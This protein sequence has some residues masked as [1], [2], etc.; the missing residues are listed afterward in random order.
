M[1]AVDHR[2]GSSAAAPALL[3]RQRGSVFTPLLEQE[4]ELQE[5]SCSVLLCALTAAPQGLCEL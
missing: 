1:I 3:P 2:G 5:D 4:N